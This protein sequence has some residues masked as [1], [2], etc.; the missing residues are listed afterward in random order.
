VDDFEAIAESL[1]RQRKDL[2]DQSDLNATSSG[3]TK[4]LLERIEE[5]RARSEKNER[6]MRESA[7]RSE[8]KKR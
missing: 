6:L 1:R 8:E 2:T 7:E 3:E 5:L 4:K